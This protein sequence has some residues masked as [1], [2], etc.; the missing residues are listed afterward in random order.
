[1]RPLPPRCRRCCAKRSRHCRANPKDDKF[2]R[3]LRRTYLE[4][5]ASQELAAEAL[6]LPFSTY[7]SHLT[8]GIARVTEWLWRRELHGPDPDAG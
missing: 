7:R 4:P 1:M 2:A 6:G 3:A 8:A 5:A